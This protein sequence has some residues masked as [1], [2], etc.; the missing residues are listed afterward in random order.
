M[1]ASEHQGITATQP[2]KARLISDAK[3]QEADAFQFRHQAFADT[4]VQAATAASTFSTDVVRQRS[5][6]AIAIDID[7]EVYEVAELNRAGLSG[8]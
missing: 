6:A 3:G 8:G 7:A 5:N 2:L 4:L 1:V